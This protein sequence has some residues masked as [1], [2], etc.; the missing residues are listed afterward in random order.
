MKCAVIYARVSTSKQA[1]GDLSIPDQLRACTN[2]CQQHNLQVV[3]QYIDLGLSATDDNRPELQRMVEHAVRRTGGFEVIVLHSQSRFFRDNFQ[4]EMYRRRLLKVGVEV[5]SITQDFGTGPNADLMRQFIGLM[6]EYFSKENA[7]HVL[8]GMEE[9]A[10]QGF[11]NGIAPFG[12][13]S[14]VVEMRGI[15]AKRKFK[16]QPEEEGSSR[17]PR[18]VNI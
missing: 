12:Y 6:D 13:Q 3:G 11:V 5:V 9:N 15:K 18:F 14:V 2:Y 17:C 1:D 10:R 8:R 7:K 4:A 16:I